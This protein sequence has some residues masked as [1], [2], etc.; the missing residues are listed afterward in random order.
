MYMYASY[1]FSYEKKNPEIATVCG[2]C[3]LFVVH[4]LFMSIFVLPFANVH[5]CGQNFTSPFLFLG[6]SVCRANITRLRF[7][8]K[9]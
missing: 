1:S 8:L 7:A 3:C 9:Q 2:R 5:L 4:S 6:L